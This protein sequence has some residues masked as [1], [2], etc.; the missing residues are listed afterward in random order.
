MLQ[1]TMRKIFLVTEGCC[2]ILGRTDNI[3]EIPNIIRAKLLDPIT[4]S[5]II[6][7]QWINED[8]YQK[9]FGNKV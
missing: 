1:A 4:K 9:E 6:R 2:T 7:P 3:D 8:V 5:I